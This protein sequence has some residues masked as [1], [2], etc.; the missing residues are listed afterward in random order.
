MQ[1]APHNENRPAPV[2]WAATIALYSAV[3]AAFAAF[4]LL[5]VEESRV[6]LIG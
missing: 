1:I 3:F 2:N 6:F 4:A 5:G